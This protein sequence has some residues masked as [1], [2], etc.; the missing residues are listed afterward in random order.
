MVGF[1][2]YIYGLSRAEGLVDGRRG[3]VEESGKFGLVISAVVVEG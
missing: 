1:E 2:I 3:E